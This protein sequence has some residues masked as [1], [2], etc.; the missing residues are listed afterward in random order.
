MCCPRHLQIP[1]SPILPFF[2]IIHSRI[3]NSL[4]YTLQQNVT[5]TTKEHAQ[6]G[7][8]VD[9]KFKSHRTPRVLSFNEIR[10]KIRYRHTS[11]EITKLDHTG[12]LYRYIRRNTI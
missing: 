7:A 5:P 12:K 11:G 6:Y 9:A 2:H 10:H 1:P 3:S 4:C 8:R